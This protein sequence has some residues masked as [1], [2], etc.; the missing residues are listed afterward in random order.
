MINNLVIGECFVKDHA[1]CLHIASA[2]QLDEECDRR[3]ICQVNRVDQSS[4]VLPTNQLAL[5]QN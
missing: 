4:Q 2:W 3:S 5:A 1:H